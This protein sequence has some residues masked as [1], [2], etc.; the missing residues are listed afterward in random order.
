MV[1]VFICFILCTTAAAL[2][3]PQ[4]HTLLQLELWIAI[5]ASCSREWTVKL[6][7]R[8]GGVGIDKHG[9]ALAARGGHTDV[10]GLLLS[11][12]CFD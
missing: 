5:I 8:I 2:I 6:Y 9:N 10:V 4:G 12:R 7:L 3:I 11:K 1:L